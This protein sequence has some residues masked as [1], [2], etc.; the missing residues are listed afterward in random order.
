ME[1]TWWMAILTLSLL[2]SQF[3][4]FHQKSKSFFAKVKWSHCFWDRFF[5]RILYIYFSSTSLNKFYAF[6]ALKSIE[7]D[8]N[9]FICTI[10]TTTTLCFFSSKT[11][12]VH[13]TSASN[14]NF[15]LF[16]LFFDTTLVSV[17]SRR[18]FSCR[19]IPWKIKL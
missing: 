18:I 4:T 19:V 3:Y 9:V 17:R 11:L 15:V 2:K 16:V 12:S 10:L 6:R 7:C 5:I 13:W 1:Q 14:Q 8:G